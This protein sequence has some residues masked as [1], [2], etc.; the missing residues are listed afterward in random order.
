MILKNGQI[1]L[2]AIEEE[3]ASVLC[4]LINDPEIEHAVVGWSYPVSLAQQKKW[5]AALDNNCGTV[6][7]AIDAGNGIIGV[8][9]LTSLDFK[10]RTA[11]MNIKLTKESQGHGYAIQAMELLIAYC[12]EEL[13]LFCLTANVL[14]SNK[15]SQKLWEKLGFRRDGVLRSRVFKANVYHDLFAY[16]LLKDEYYAGN[17]Q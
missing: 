3:D 6:R 7:Y 13:N 17:R 1:L 16:S 2:R 12:F 8:A 14:E 9:M 4:E 10:N 5:I 15:A 11:N